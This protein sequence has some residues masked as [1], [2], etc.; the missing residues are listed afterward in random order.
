MNKLLIIC[1]PT[2]TGKTQLALSLAKQFSG[3]LISA[4]S[5]QVYKGMDI[6]TGKDVPATAHR[7]SSDLHVEFRGKNYQFPVY[8]IDQVALWM[9]DVV[10]PDEDF[11]VSHYQ[12]L[13]K[14]V[15]YHVWNKG[16][17]P[18][19]VGGTGFYL[20][21]IIAPVETSAVPPDKNL[22]IKLNNWSTG[23]LQ[24]KLQE[25]APHIWLKMNE[26]DR[27]NPRRLIRK[28]EI[29]LSTNVDTLTVNWDKQPDTLFIGLTAPLN[30]LYQRINQRVE[31]RVRQGIIEEIRNLLAQGYAWDL[32]AM[33]GLGYRQWRE[34]FDLVGTG[35]ISL[36]E[37]LKEETLRR[38]KF[39]EHA[40]ARRQLTWFRKQTD[41]H[42][43][44][45]TKSNLKTQVAAMMA[46][47]YTQK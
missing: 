18:I 34:Y 36:E 5:R 17:L 42:W 2:A 37:K 45:I 41:I 24:E 28:I 35:G 40:F 11:S 44:D 15:I 4:D 32:P 16:K 3:E 22:R 31:A 10:N 30:I 23:Q 39:A 20:R 12:Y 46:K 9:Y 14:N 25:L 47:W 1:G 7:K 6:G 27:H 13:V 26:S 38:W 33:S 8:F 19:V 21:S 29:R 43:F